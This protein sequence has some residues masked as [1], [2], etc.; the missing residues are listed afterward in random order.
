[1][2]NSRQT[3]PNDQL[4]RGRDLE[5]YRALAELAKDLILE[6]SA[7]IVVAAILKKARDLTGSAFGY[8][9]KIDQK[10][11][12]FICTTLTSEIYAECKVDDKKLVF[13]DFK[14]L[15]G[16]VL[17]NKQA[18]LSNNLQDD[19]RAEGLPVGHIPIKRFLSVPV[20]SDGQLLG[21]ISL[22]NP[23]DDYDENDLWILEQF[24]EIYKL[25]LQRQ[26]ELQGLE[27]SCIMTD[28]SSDALCVVDPETSQFLEVNEAAYLR[29][30]YSRSELLAKR[31]IDI[32]G[33]D[34]DMDAWTEHIRRLRDVP[35]LVFEGEQIRKDGSI[36]PV[37]VNVR[38]VQQ[39]GREY[40]VSVA[41]DITERME[42]A[43][44]VLEEKNKLEAVLAGLGD[45]LTMQD[46]QFRIL[47][48]N[49]QHKLQQGDCHSQLCYEAYQHKEVV[50][51]GCLLAKCFADGKIHH[52][53]SSFLDSSGRTVYVE[54]SAS[55]V[56]DANGY[57]YAGIESVRNITDR[58]LL[59]KK[60]QQAQ[61]HEA[62]GTLAG[63]IAHD[64]N[65][66]LSVIMG[67]GELVQMDLEQGGDTW[68]MQE[69]V[70]KASIRARELVK[71]ILSFSRHDEKQLMP[72]QMSLIVKEALKM[73][74]SSIPSTIEIKQFIDPEAGKVLADPTQVHQI[75]MNLC[76]NA[77]HAMR[78]KGGVLT[79]E[80]Q[81][82][83][84]GESI[85]GKNGVD[86]LPG[87]YVRLSVGD[88][89][90]GI[91]VADQSRIFDPYFTTKV[92]GEGTGLGLAVVQGIVHK[93]KGQVTVTSD[94]GRGADFQV[95]LPCTDDDL[96][97]K[98]KEGTEVI[99]HGRE[100]ILVVDDEENVV[101]LV[102]KI[103]TGLGYQ[104]LGVKSS[105]AALRIFADGPEDLDLIITDM[106]MPYMTGADLAESIL[107]VRPEIPI[108]LCT[109]YSDLIDKK[110]AK[111]LGISQLLMKPIGREEL[112]YA[113]RQALDSRN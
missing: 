44:S 98:D 57:I 87:R 15:W 71:Q 60:L 24:A 31:V 94:P 68:K 9:G 82:F 59:E 102:Q 101:N 86:L 45:G 47:Y 103:L 55:P 91:E 69:Q 40:V 1:M 54:I 106:T 92:K 73:L 72:L 84:A 29:L 21:Q 51:E 100:R 81:G 25:A 108:I 23:P 79:V 113:V 2:K 46:R 88:T 43:N 52:R 19:E 93:C 56:R 38:L 37:E 10:T 89:G 49:K 8:V 34:P 64:F 53:E 20:I 16:W 109:G 104:V 67:Y 13:H 14:G 42:A 12:D 76:T 18:I 83:L 50:C 99:P 85:N 70:L 30:G 48:Q 95:Y 80:L 4:E 6:E 33:S 62:I 111:S 17:T 63:G 36:L 58:K 105:E 32:L 61:K 110:R 26:K 7:D 22:A 107:V 3:T 5:V 78:I 41:R 75:M 77:Y 35:F 90:H 112:A 97:S 27:L 39:E 66:I 65:N 28:R 74:R 96:S 11:G